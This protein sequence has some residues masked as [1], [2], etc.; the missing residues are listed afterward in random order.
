[1][2]VKQGNKVSI[3]ASSKPIKAFQ[4]HHAQAATDLSAIGKSTD[5]CLVPDR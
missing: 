1:M 4:H 2:P 5:L 3:T